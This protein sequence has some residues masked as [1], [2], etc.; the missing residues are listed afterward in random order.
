MENVQY[1][2][3]LQVSFFSIS[4]FSA[5]FS[6]HFVFFTQSIWRLSFLCSTSTI[7]ASL[8]W[9]LWICTH[10]LFSAWHSSIIIFSISRHL[11]LS[12]S[13]FFLL[14]L[15][16]LLH[17][18]IS[19]HLL[20]G[21]FWQYY[22]SFSQSYHWMAMICQF[23]LV[24]NGNLHSFQFQFIVLL[25]GHLIKIFF[26]GDRSPGISTRFHDY[27]WR[28]SGK[29]VE[30]HKLRH[31]PSRSSSHVELY[32][33]RRWMSRSNIVLTNTQ[34]LGY[35]VKHLYFS[36]LSSIRLSATMHFMCIIPFPLPLSIIFSRTIVCIV[37]M[38]CSA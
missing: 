5:G 16:D 3:T 38:V 20:L 25:W 8:K 31:E 6:F 17:S 34:S 12:L 11:L 7:F 18:R 37:C 14:S 36:S 4:L 15:I 23:Y 19:I 9:P 2:C 24:Y 26:S 10:E 28:H 27:V 30:I 35:R 21:G 1:A 22:F 29:N 33:A 13:T 32:Q